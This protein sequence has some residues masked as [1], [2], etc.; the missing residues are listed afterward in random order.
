MTSPGDGD[1][2]GARTVGSAGTLPLPVGSIGGRGQVGF[3]H[4]DADISG[5]VP[6]TVIQGF[7]PTGQDLHIQTETLAASGHLV[8]RLGL[9]PG[10]ADQPLPRGSPW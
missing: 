2:V 9:L 6:R 7:G 8:E 4:R 10:G 1:A 5:V 3:G